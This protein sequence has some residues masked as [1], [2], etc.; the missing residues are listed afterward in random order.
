[1]RIRAIPGK[2]SWGSD[3]GLKDQ[4]SFVV[5]LNAFV[6]V[7]LFPFSSHAPSFNT[8]P[9]NSC[10]SL[11]MRMTRDE[12]FLNLC[13][14]LFMCYNLETHHKATQSNCRY[15]RLL[16]SAIQCE[17]SYNSVSK[18]FISHKY[19]LQCMSLFVL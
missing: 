7:S 16:I 2:K 11:F 15:H 5:V 18:I 3:L 13:L 9:R 10:F 6:V 4:Q 12:L 8:K 1:M 19:G 17:K 14:D